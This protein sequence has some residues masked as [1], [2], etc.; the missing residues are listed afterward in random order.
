M[1]L[2][3]AKWGNSLAVRL[4]A[5][6]TRQSGIANGDYLQANVDASG[7]IR[8]LPNKQVADRAAVLKR[9]SALHKT[10]PQTRAVVNALRKEVRY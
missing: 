6:Y 1:R 3:V 8:L 4:P 5:S 10:L 7:E 2:Q 9:V